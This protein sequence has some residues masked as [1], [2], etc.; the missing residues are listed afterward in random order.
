MVTADDACHI[1]SY[2]WVYIFASPNAYLNVT[3]VITGAD[4]IV[5]IPNP[6]RGQ[7]TVKGSLGVSNDEEVTLEI[8][9]M[10]GQVV[11]TGKVVAHNGV[12]NEQ[13]SLS[14]AIANGMYLLNVHSETASKVFHMVIEQ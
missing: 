5:V 1:T 14:G 7:F 2:Q 6:N 10:L 13:V 3:P 11:Y 8:T 4:D 12:L 9:D